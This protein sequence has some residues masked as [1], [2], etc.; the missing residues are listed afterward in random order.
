MRISACI[1]THAFFLRLSKNK[2]LT[3]H[4]YFSGIYKE[5]FLRRVVTNVRSVVVMLLDFET[6]NM[7][8]FSPKSIIFFYTNVI[9]ISCNHFWHLLFGNFY[10]VSTIRPKVLDSS[11]FFFKCLVPYQILSFVLAVICRSV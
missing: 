11:K 6:V 4:A 9:E 10:K 5:I 1:Y 3:R 2:I 8:R 7:V